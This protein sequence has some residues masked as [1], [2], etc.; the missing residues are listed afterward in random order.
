MGN[1]LDFQQRQKDTFPSF[2]LHPLV[3]ILHVKVVDDL[4]LAQSLPSINL[5]PPLLPLSEDAKERGQEEV[6]ND[7]EEEDEGH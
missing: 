1:L 3:Q 5:R 2:S 7:K 4:Q 6:E